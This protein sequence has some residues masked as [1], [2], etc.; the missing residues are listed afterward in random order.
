V[1][2][3][4]VVDDAGFSLAG[5]RHYGLAA[6]ADPDVDLADVIQLL[7]AKLEQAIDIVRLNPAAQEARRDRNDDRFVIPSLKLQPPEPTCIEI[8]S[9]FRPQSVSNLAPPLLK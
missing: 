9:Q 1:T 8:L 2:W 3:R 4:P 5:N 7:V 6:R